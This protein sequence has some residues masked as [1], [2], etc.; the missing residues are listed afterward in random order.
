LRNTAASSAVGKT[1]QPIHPLVHAYDFDPPETMIVRSAMAG[2]G[3]ERRAR[4]AVEDAA[5]VD[6]VR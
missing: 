5:L 6:P 4:L 1:A 3:G 2:H